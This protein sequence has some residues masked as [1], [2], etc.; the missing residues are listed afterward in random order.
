MSLVQLFAQTAGI[1]V[2]PSWN[3]L[4]ETSFHCLHYVCPLISFTTTFTKNWVVWYGLKFSRLLEADLRQSRIRNSCY[5]MIK[6]RV[7][8][9]SY[10]LFGLQWWFRIFNS[11][12]VVYRNSG[13]LWAGNY[14]RNLVWYFL[15]GILHRNIWN[16]DYDTLTIPRL[17]ECDNTYEERRSRYELVQG[18]VW[19]NLRHTR[20]RCDHKKIRLQH[21]MN[22]REENKI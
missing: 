6:L 21:L 5:C 7:M 9:L 22:A 2:S 1:T 15:G 19:M 16:P 17:C 14:S 20:V 18:V 10:N 12:E 8:R 3:S 13:K 4:R 11:M